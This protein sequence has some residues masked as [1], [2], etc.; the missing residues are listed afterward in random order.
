[1]QDDWLDDNGPV[2]DFQNSTSIAGIFHIIHNSTKDIGIA[3]QSYNDTVSDMSHVANLIRRK[4]TQDRLL[5]TC[6]SHGPDVH[7]KGFIRKFDGKVHQ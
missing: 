1:M 7:L 5:E 6:F 4:A 3:M 2:Y